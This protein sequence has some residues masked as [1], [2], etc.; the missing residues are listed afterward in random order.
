MIPASIISKYGSL[1]LRSG[2]SGARREGL[3]FYRLRYLQ[4]LANSHK[5]YLLLYQTSLLQL[6]LP[7][8]WLFAYC[9]ITTEMSLL[10]ISLYLYRL[11]HHCSPISGQFFSVT[12]S[13]AHTVYSNLKAQTTVLFL[14]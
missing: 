11:Y 1:S 5:D 8:C 14:H 12:P 2:E 9:T 6:I 3:I 7:A 13:T 10:P 4:F